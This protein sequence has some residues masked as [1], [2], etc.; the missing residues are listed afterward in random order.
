MK[1]I[2]YLEKLWEPK[3]AKDCN[4][5]L[6]GVGKLVYNLISD[7]KFTKGK[8]GHRIFISNSLKISDR[9]LDR[10]RDGHSP[11]PIPFLYELLILWKKTC[12]KNE[13][14][15]KRKYDELFNK[16]IY[17][18][19]AKGNK[20]KLPKRITPKL[21]YLL[22][23]L[24][25]DGCLKD[26][27]KIGERSGS[28]RYPIHFASNT[29][30]FADKILNPLFYKLFEKKLGIYKIKGNK[31]FEVTLSSKV[32]YLFLYRVC[33]IPKGKKKGQIS[34][35][36][37]I[38]NSSKNIQRSFVAGFFDGDGT[39]YVKN[40]E[41]AISQADK[42]FLEELSVVINNLGIDTRRMYTQRK[43]LGITYCLSLRW[44]ALK[45]F[46]DTVPFLEP[47]KIERAKE[48]M[49]KVNK[50]KIV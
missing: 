19:I 40:K 21:A 16:T 22:G 8:Y 2:N 20:V 30:H 23:Y 42:R 5:R 29:F 36:K 10:W 35:P 44:S 47:N 15:L 37:V 1:F 13:L 33:E 34:I 50:D 9:T 11:I 27:K 43:E 24:L 3:F 45:R 41:I 26:Y 38:L 12:N 49:E 46:V 4:I 7:I 48:L 17:F 18:S 14:D 32:I 39:I 25:S 28:P 31:C 6:N